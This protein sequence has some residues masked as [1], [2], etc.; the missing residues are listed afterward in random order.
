MRVL[1]AIAVA[2]FAAAVTLLAGQAGAQNLT[3]T[4]GL[5]CPLPSKAMM[6]A[7]LMFGRN[8]GGHPGVSEAAFARFVAAEITPRFPAGLT[9]IDAAGQWRDAA[10]GR[11][12]HERSKM[13]VLMIGDA[14]DAR[15]RIAAIAEAYKKRFRQQSVGVVTRPV[16]ASF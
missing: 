3:G 2:A 4:E 16:C 7:E 1:K 6:R 11:V 15:E 14:P 10:T 8:I 12:V 9:V 13:V 5:S